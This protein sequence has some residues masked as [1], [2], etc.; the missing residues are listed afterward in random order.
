MRVLINTPSPQRMGGVA[1]LYAS[2]RPHF[3]PEVSYF[4]FGRHT[5]SA[6]LVVRASRVVYDYARFALWLVRYWP[7]VVQLNPSLGTAA[8]VRDGVFVA[9]ARL[10]GRKVVIFMHGWNLE[11]EQRMRRN[12]LWLFRGFYFNAHAFVVLASE[13]A[14]HL[15]EM[16]YMGPIHVGATAIGDDIVEYAKNEVPTR[17][18]DGRDFNILFL[19]RVER[20]KGIMEALAAYAILKARHPHVS[21]TVAGA[22]GALE[23]ARHF[24]RE[25]NL[26]DVQFL[27]YVRGAQKADAFSCASCYLFPSYTEGMPLSVLEAMAFGLP[28]ITRSVGALADFFRDGEMGF[29][30]E[31]KDPAVFAQL[32]ERLM[33][34]PAL[35]DHIGR[36]NQEYA[37]RRFT[38]SGVAAR[39]YAIYQSVVAG[40]A[41]GG[42]AQASE[43][44]RGEGSDGD[45]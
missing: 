15:R 44:S 45:S 38:P 41:S 12:W 7:K 10:T 39:L 25:Q 17:P 42:D 11:Y 18:H 32:V 2:L 13:F 19:T 8:L 34:Q 6:G 40:D 5:R 26:S 20:E 16:G 22:G 21:M 29:V 4:I 28:V 23:A 35:C 24:V 31:S 36:H 33:A 9:I 1:A 14:C 30:T 27:G 37:L 3:S 43:G